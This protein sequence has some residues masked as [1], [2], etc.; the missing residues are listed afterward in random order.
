MSEAISS[1]AMTIEEPFYGCFCDLRTFIQ[2][3]SMSV[4]SRYIHL[5][6]IRVQAFRNYNNERKAAY[7]CQY[8]WS[9]LSGY[10][11]SSKQEGMVEYSAV[12]EECGGAIPKGRAAYRKQLL[13]DMSEELEIKNDIF[14]QSVIGGTAFLRWVTETFFPDRETKEQPAGV[15]TK[16][17]RQKV[18]ILS[19]I[20]EETGKDLETIKCEKGHLRRLAM[21]LLF[22]YGGLRGAEIG[23]L[24]GVG[25]SAVSQERKRL[26]ESK[27]KNIKIE[28]LKRRLEDKLSIIKI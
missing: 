13:S 10:L 4:L 16:Y 2:S 12:L 27:K 3:G 5:N 8:P 9:S 21:D 22:H 7:L 28:E 17:Y 23:G 24:F 25:Y 6:P 11:D 26:R 19:L 20:A 15:K 1:E 18:T 14:S